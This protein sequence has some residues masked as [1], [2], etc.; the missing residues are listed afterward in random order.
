MRLVRAPCWELHG[1][2]YP[3]KFAGFDTLNIYYKFFNVPSPANCMGYSLLIP[4]WVRTSRF[5]A[6]PPAPQYYENLGKLALRGPL[7]T[8]LL[9]YSQPLDS[10]LDALTTRPQL[11]KRA[12]VRSEKLTP[13]P[14][15]LR[16]RPCIKP[17]LKRS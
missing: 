6:K 3:S 15:W 11:R 13:H 4:A 7:I 12:A 5:G 16:P 9:R 8:V 17:E 1:T 2:V 14:C 10:E